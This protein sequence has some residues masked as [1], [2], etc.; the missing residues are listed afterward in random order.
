VV[1]NFGRSQLGYLK[2]APFFKTPEMHPK[3]AKQDSRIVKILHSYQGL[4][5]E[6][7]DCN[8]FINV[9]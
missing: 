7:K 2:M 9:S 8:L 3:A 4:F 6:I 1:V 5:R